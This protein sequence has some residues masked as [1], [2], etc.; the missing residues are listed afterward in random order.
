M[1]FN[2]S[3]TK[4]P[5]E[6]IIIFDGGTGREIERRGGPFRQPEWSALAL[7]QDPDIVRD[8]HL[9]YITAG[10]TA[11]TTNTYAVVPF[12]LG[13]ERYNADGK[14]LL[15]LAVDLATDAKKESGND[16]VKIIGSIPPI[17]GS[18]EPDKFDEA[19]AGPIVDDF[20]GTYH[21]KVDILLLETIGSVREA[22]F[23]L[24]KIQSS[25][26]AKLPI[27]LSFCVECRYD[28]IQPRLMT[29]ELLKDAIPQLLRD[30][31]LLSSVS[32]LLVNC[33]DVRLVDDCIKELN[34]LDLDC[35]IGAYPNAFSIPPPDAANH[36][37]RLVDF[38]I[39]P[40]VL[41]E[42]ATQWVAHGA[43]VLGGCCGVGPDHIRAMASLREE[44]QQHCN[45][46]ESKSKSADE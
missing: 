2:M 38:N 44:D 6:E 33:C 10:A 34:E 13:R 19:F 16:S 3:E 12:H 35:R 9:S 29:G 39:T 25:K 17:C 43:T 11:I 32:V 37:L 26:L 23:Y 20:L 42:Q 22:C 40:S 46:D 7:Y 45:D 36:T 18:Y 27:W 14:R 31:N 4:Q 41:K 30:A 5:N 21:D 24:N 8:V 15:Q 1:R 28:E